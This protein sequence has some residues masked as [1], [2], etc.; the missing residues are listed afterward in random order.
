M[1]GRLIVRETNHLQLNLIN[2]HV[3]SPHV[4]PLCYQGDDI[5]LTIICN[6]GRRDQGLLLLITGT[7]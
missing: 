2:P 7:S 4:R 3:S 1:T 6:K 5:Q